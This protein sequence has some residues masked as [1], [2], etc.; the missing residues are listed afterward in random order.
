M[1][2]IYLSHSR[3]GS[4]KKNHKYVTRK[5]VNGKWVYTY[6]S[7]QSK[8]YQKQAETIKG[9]NKDWSKEQDSSY[10]DYIK[11]DEDYNREMSK[12][13]T[14]A[15]NYDRAV[16]SMNRRAS[17][18]ERNLTA[19]SAIAKNIHDSN[20]NYAK[21]NKIGRDTAR[22][23]MAD[24]TYKKRLKS[25]AR[26]AKLTYTKQKAYKTART[27]KKNILKGKKKVSEL[28]ERLQNAYEDQKRR[29]AG[30]KAGRKSAQLSKERQKRLKQKNT[31]KLNKKQRVTF[32]DVKIR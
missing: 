22:K 30:K 11:A 20:I 3:K 12:F 28:I 18:R 9:Y 31:I 7:D 24:P 32:S 27:V 21:A 6:P 13:G 29:Y 10:L 26:K 5:M 17:A 16:D 1:G 14:S 19:Q 2:D 25:N 8:T 23:V 4:Q 15:Y